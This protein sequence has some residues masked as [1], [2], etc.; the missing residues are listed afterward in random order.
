ME[1]E[2]TQALENSIVTNPQ[3]Q[4]KMAIIKL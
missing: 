2:I 1:N 4:K 3:N